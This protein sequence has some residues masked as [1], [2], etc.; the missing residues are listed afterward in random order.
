MGYPEKRGKGKST[1]WRA[2]YKAPDGTYPS[3]KD[4]AGDVVRFHRRQEAQDAADDAEADI[5]AGRWVAP[6]QKSK[7]VGEWYA[8]WRPAQHY[9]R[10]NTEQTYDQHWRKHIEPR[11]GDEPIS[12]ILPIHIQGWETELRKTYESSTVTSIM[13]PLRH[14]LED[15][16]VNLRLLHSPLPPKRRPSAGRRKRASIG[17]AVPLE[18]WE[19]ICERLAPADALLARIV[20][21][22]GMRWSEVSAMRIR[23]L[24]LTAAGERPAAAVYYLH[25][26]VGAV[27]EDVSGHR[28]YGEPKSG[29]GREW[30]LPPFLAQ[31]VID[32]VA[33]LRT[34]GPDVHADDKD[35]LFPDHVGRPHSES[36]WKRRW[37]AACDGRAATRHKDEWEAIW[38]KLRLHDGKHSHG[39]MMDDLGTHRVMREYRLGHSDGSARAVYEHPTPD[40]RRSLLIGLQ[41]RWETWQAT[42]PM[43]IVSPDSPR[44][45]F[46]YGGIQV[47]RA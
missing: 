2:R 16:V 26:D 44:D 14:M 12:G 17:V 27:H 31:Q 4:D 1:Y 20:Y 34:P 36:N 33:Q 21:W 9:A 23:F 10:I 22:T 15:A 5:R 43:E 3:V 45:L 6:D 30:E 18:T 37:R 35:L 13:A 39:T 19:A 41:A 32:H 29:P 47:K 28:H 25:P 42:R 11:W 40:M 7:T 24:T 8:E 38:P 46:E